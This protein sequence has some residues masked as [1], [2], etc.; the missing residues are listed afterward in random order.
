M[1]FENSF[2]SDLS[3]KID[4]WPQSNPIL[5]NATNDDTSSKLS[6]L[7][8]PCNIAKN[9]FVFNENSSGEGNN[10]SQSFD[11][12]NESPVVILNENIHE[13][14]CD[15]TVFKMTSDSEKSGEIAIEPVHDSCKFFSYCVSF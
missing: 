13:T 8:I 3:K 11:D 12:A 7:L 10:N 6:L 14:A 2:E 1:L 15:V 9:T 4:D 5:L